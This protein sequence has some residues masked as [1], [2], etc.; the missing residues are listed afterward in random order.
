M[1]LPRNILERRTD[2]QALEKSKTQGLLEYLHIALKLASFKS[3]IHT[4]N[5]A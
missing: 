2:A 5:N 1:Y 4:D 3:F